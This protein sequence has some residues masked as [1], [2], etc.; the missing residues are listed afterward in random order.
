LIIT[1]LL[2]D[3]K[4]RRYTKRS[5]EAV[6]SVKQTLH[7]STTYKNKKTACKLY[8]WLFLCFLDVLRNSAEKRLIP[9]S[10]SE[11]SKIKYLIVRI[12]LKLTSHYFYDG[13]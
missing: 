6:A 7:F 11:I 3:A 8:T 12:D 4:L 2:S 9:K 10:E 5:I 13:N 1:L